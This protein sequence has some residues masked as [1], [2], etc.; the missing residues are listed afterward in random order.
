MVATSPVLAAEF[1]SLQ[2]RSLSVGGLAKY[3][4]NQGLSE[5]PKAKLTADCIKFISA[6][7]CRLLK[8]GSVPWARDCGSG[9]HEF[10][11]SECVLRASVTD[12]IINPKP[13][14]KL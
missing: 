3:F 1:L 13:T 11:A 2:Q 14:N 4:A 5:V 10:G 8:T 12:G 6:P 7:W 9:R